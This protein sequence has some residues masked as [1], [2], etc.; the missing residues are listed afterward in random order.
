ML[1]ILTI[2]FLSSSKKYCNN[3]SFYQLLLLLA[4]DINF[5][6]GLFHNHQ[7]LYHDKSNVFKQRGQHLYHL[8]INSLLLKIGEFRCI[9]KLT[10]SAVIRI[11]ELKLDDS[12]L[13]SHS[14]L[15]DWFLCQG[16][17]GT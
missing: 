3:K 17:T 4:G 12:M 6:P 14:K 1:I 9:G 13:T 5:N 11:P 7:H 16:N 10:N 2:T 15:I 8:N